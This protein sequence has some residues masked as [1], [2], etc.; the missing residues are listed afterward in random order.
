MIRTST[1]IES[2]V[3]QLDALGAVETLSDL[4]A[5]GA[6][7]SRFQEH[8]SEATMD[9]LDAL[10]LTELSSPEAA[11]YNVTTQCGIVVALSAINPAAGVVAALRLA[12]PPM[13]IALGDDTW[14]TVRSSALPAGTIA[15]SSPG[16][17]ARAVPAA[18]G[19]QL[20]GRWHCP[21]HHRAGWILVPA[22]SRGGTTLLM[23]IARQQFTILPRAGMPRAFLGL[24]SSMVT[25]TDEFVPAKQAIPLDALLEGKH[26]APG[27]PIA[28]HCLMQPLVPRLCA[29]A[30]A[31]AVGVARGMLEQVT[32]ERSG[33]PGAALAPES[34]AA[35]ATRLL[36]A[37]THLQEL[38]ESVDRHIRTDEPWTDLERAWCRAHLTGATRQSWE[39][40]DLIRTE[41]CPA[42]TQASVLG[43]L[44]ADMDV[45]AG[46]ELLGP[47]ATIALGQ[48]LSGRSVTDTVI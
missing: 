10:H 19:W 23:L 46:H 8:L 47:D 14:Q 37:E 13:M 39:I 15:F 40:A 43:Q 1:D 6:P 28:Q 21:G 32:T 42:D 4:L 11:P 5:A 9:A 25:L 31:V 22:R 17:T 35:L 34:V 29:L 44:C 48:M 26:G 2:I 45:M 12:T 16:P 20:Q 27:S 24:G 33:R 38:V 7:Q 36:Y 30:A 18:G 41:C 3:S